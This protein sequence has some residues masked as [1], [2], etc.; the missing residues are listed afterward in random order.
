MCIVNFIAVTDA[1]EGISEQSHGPHLDH[2][3]RQH[4]VGVCEPPWP[5]L[6][7][8]QDWQV[9]AAVLS[10]IPESSDAVESE[11]RQMISVK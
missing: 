8:G 9:I 6:G 2:S 4:E 11:A 10:S 5:C 1:V 7:R 3:G